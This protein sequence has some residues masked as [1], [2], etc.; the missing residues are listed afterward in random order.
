MTVIGKIVKPDVDRYKNKK[1]VYFVRNLFLPENATDE[2]KS[3]FDRYWSEV[4]EH[5]GRLEAAGK[6]SKVFCESIYM[7]GEDAMKI[8]RAMNEQLETLVK[9]KV[10]EGAEF[11]PL[12]DKEI[13]GA[14]V[15]WNNCLMIVRTEGVYELVH[16]HLKE[17]VNDRFEYIKSVLRE[18]IMDGE[19]G[20]LIMRDGDE[21]LLEL[22]DDME[23]FFVTP[24][25]YDDLIRFIRDAHSGK[26]FWRTD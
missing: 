26:E 11:T 21:K 2:Y 1:K 6:I 10:V 19:A 15:D 4:Q 9:K 13:F 3:I 16:H 17:S 5:L 14:Y 8:L 7:T 25:A 22:P 18:N 20:L 12:E 24:P 23:L